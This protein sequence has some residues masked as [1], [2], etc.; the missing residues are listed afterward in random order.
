[1]YQTIKQNTTFELVEKKSKFIGHLIYIENKLEA[2]A[3]IKEWKKKFFDAR[4]NCFAFRVLEKEAIYEKASDDG[5]PSGTAGAPML[6]ILQKNNLCN[7]LIIV[8]RYFGGI[9]L[10][11]GGLV[12]C[13]AGVTMGAIEKADKIAIELGTE[14]T[15]E[16]DY[17]NFQNLQYYC[18]K[19]GIKIIESI[20]EEKITCHIIMNNKIKQK[21]L[22]DIA[23]QKLMITKVKEL[24]TRLVST[25]NK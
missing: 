2:E 18:Q 15:V 1:M 17:A 3:K 25:T 4:H 8:T 7:V 16:I 6:N 11:T 5:E 20:Y 21:F 14:F 22:E 13:Y 10:G 24:E 19:N 23:K 9:L 12:R